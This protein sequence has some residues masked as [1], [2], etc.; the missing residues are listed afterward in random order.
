MLSAEIPPTAPYQP[1]LPYSDL[2][3]LTP[4]QQLQNDILQH[5]VESNY[6][7]G[8]MLWDINNGI[9]SL[10][11]QD[12]QQHTEAIILQ[13]LHGANTIFSIHVTVHTSQPAPVTFAVSIPTYNIYMNALSISKT[14]A[15]LFRK[16][17]PTQVYETANQIMEQTL[18]FSS[19]KDLYKHWNFFVKHVTGMLQFTRDDE[20]AYFVPMENHKT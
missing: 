8:Y 18:H 19:I 7:N 13:S 4:L 10:Y 16:R 2:E 1:Q 5:Q 12:T 15:L 6:E 3:T 14:K 17:A 20:G 11:D 9:Q